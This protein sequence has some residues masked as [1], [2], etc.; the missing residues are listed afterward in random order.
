MVIGFL[1]LSFL[2]GLAVKYSG[3]KEA[4]QYDYSE[5]D[6]GFES[7]IKSSF[8]DLKQQPL[9]SLQR[10]R[11]EE[12]NKLA[13]SIGMQ[14]ESGT[15]KEELPAGV[16]ININTALAGDLTRLP[17]IG[18]VMAERIIDYRTKQG[19]FKSAEELMNVKGIGEK[20]FEKMKEHISVK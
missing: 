7:K 9:D 16:I 3:W 6:E 13:D 20:K 18:E 10:Q 11:A 4:Y 17:G 19:G 12:L 14:I 1:L 8:T 2:T 15:T 5:S